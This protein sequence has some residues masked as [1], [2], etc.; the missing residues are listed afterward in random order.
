MPI[1]ERRKKDNNASMI[2]RNDPANWST[3]IIISNLPRRRR[4]SS[5]GI[6]Y[7]LQYWGISFDSR[8]RLQNIQVPKAPAYTA[9]PSSGG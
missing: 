2:L 3:L 6:G 1:K 7:E 8:Q 4:D 5:V 9:S